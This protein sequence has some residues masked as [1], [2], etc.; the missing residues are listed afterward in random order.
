MAKKA[1]N[2]CFPIPE[3][4]IKKEGEKAV[5]WDDVS[6]IYRNLTPEEWVRQIIISFFI[7]ELNYSKNLIQIERGFKLNDQLK[8]TDICIFNRSG[9]VEIM[10]ECKSPEVKLEMKTW[11]QISH[12]QSY[13]KEAN[14]LMI[15]NGIDFELYDIKNQNIIK[16]DLNKIPKNI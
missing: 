7:K 2:I 16:N 13:H 4:K 5:I 14:Y 15:S 10:I 8:R 12:Y 6:K 3:F 9:K 11:N 1:Q